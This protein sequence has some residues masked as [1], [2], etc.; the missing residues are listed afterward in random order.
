MIRRPN[1]R[2]PP[3]RLC[4]WHRYHQRAGEAD[5]AVAQEMSL[6]PVEVRLLLVWG[7][8]LGPVEVRLLLVWG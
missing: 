6:G 2:R 3:H 7:W 4:R 5:F 8:V 1:R